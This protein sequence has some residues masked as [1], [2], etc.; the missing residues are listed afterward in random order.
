[1]SLLLS[2]KD[3][4]SRIGKNCAIHST[5][6]EDMMGRA[7]STYRKEKHT[8]FC[9]GNLKDVWMTYAEMGDNFRINLKRGYDRID[10]IYLAQDGDKWQGCVYTVMNL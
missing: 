6:M 3:I 2:T 1:M 10:W 9:L 4:T 8:A 7:Y 5:I